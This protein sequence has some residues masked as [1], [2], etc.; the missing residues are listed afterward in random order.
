MNDFNDQRREAGSKFKYNDEADGDHDDELGKQFIVPFDEVLFLVKDQVGCS[1]H[2]H[3][4]D[5]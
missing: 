3:Q 5:E 2:S 4:L 1:S